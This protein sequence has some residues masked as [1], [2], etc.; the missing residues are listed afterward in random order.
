MLC[1]CTWP[2][3]T[4]RSLRWGWYKNWTCLLVWHS[5]LF[6]DR[7]RECQALEWL[8]GN[9]CK[10]AWQGWSSYLNAGLIAD[11]ANDL[12]RAIKSLDIQEEED[13]RWTLGEKDGCMFELPQQEGDELESSTVTGRRLVHA[14][15]GTSPLFIHSPGRFMECHHNLLDMLQARSSHRD[16]RWRW[17]DKDHKWKSTPPP[18]KHPTPYPS[19]PPTKYPTP[20]PTSQ[21][22]SDY[23]RRG[24]LADRGWRKEGG[25]PKM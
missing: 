16:L 7:H 13:D 15:T 11:K 20:H 14:E 5:R 2:Y 9:S 25:E 23:S 22:G 24:L 6:V 19:S 3:S 18:T 10:R 21:Y 12:L 8:H 4:W 17:G 1:D